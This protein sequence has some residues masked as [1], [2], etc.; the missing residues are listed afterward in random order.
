M[1]VLFICM[2][3]PEN[4]EDT[5]QMQSD[6]PNIKPDQAGQD[7]P[8]SEPENIAIRHESPLIEV[9]DIYHKIVFIA[10]SNKIHIYI[11]SS[12]NILKSYSG[13]L[14]ELMNY[15]S[16][17]LLSEYF[18]I[19]QLIDWFS[20]GNWQ[21]T[22]LI[23]E[24]KLIFRVGLNTDH[25]M[26]PFVT[27]DVGALKLKSI[28]PTIGDELNKAQRKRDDDKRRIK[29]E[30]RARKQREKKEKQITIAQYIMVFLN[31]L[32][33]ACLWA[34]ELRVVTDLA[35]HKIE[36]SAINRTLLFVPTIIC[37]LSV[38]FVP[39]FHDMIQSRYSN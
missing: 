33:F 6:C 5:A 18:S 2:L 35:V 10:Q 23:T 22:R 31:V 16:N 25:I 4:M 36:L 27:E 38:L 12:K 1:I 9:D 8:Q 28:S 30:K 15:G 19:E 26:I 20:H 13:T 21:M 14:D 3:Y 11:V 29:D 24:S 39:F 7:K 17:G 34:F 32:S 37:L